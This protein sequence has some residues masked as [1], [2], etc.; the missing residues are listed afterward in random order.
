[1]LIK[2]SGA[3]ELEVVVLTN[4]WKWH[5]PESES[6]IISALFTLTPSGSSAAT[7]IGT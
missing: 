4:R 2:F 1:M 7:G 5:Q 6:L 3:R